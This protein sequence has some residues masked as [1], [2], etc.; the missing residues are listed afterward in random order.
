MTAIPFIVIYIYIFPSLLNL[1][2]QSSSSVPVIVSVQLVVIKYDLIKRTIVENTYIQVY[3][4]VCI[5][6]YSQR[7]RTTIAS[8]KSRRYFFQHRW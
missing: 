7:M 3:V 1:H 2:P 4:C 6:T 8:F 5:Y